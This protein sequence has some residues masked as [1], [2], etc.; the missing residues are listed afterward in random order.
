MRQLCTLADERWISEDDGECDD[1]TALLLCIQPVGEV[2]PLSDLEPEST[3]DGG[4]ERG[5]SN[6]EVNVH[7]QQ[8][9]NPA[10]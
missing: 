1:I 8:Q 5:L 9:Q 6:E 4:S 10:E 2:E 7:Q 3:A